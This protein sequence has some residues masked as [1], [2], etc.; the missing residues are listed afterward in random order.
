M[1][2]EW[3]RE[4][5]KGVAAIAVNGGGV[6]KKKLMVM[7]N[8]I[9]KRVLSP[10]ATL[11]MRD[12]NMKNI[13]VVQLVASLCPWPV[14]HIFSSMASSESRKSNILVYFHFH[15]CCC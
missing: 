1:L 12:R 5:I 14:S 9:K 3:G 7:V 15:F 8:T 2:E 4:K 10:R 11:L 13:H 6:S